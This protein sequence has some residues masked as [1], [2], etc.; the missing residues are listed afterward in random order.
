VCSRLVELSS[1][2]DSLVDLR[3]TQRVPS[4]KQL[5]ESQKG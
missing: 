5:T 3:K 1:L 2:Q 4:E